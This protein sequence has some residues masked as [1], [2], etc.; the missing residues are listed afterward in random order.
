MLPLINGYQ[1]M[2]L[3]VVRK[4]K[5][6]FELFASFDHRI[7]EGLLVTNFLSELKRRILSYYYLNNGVANI[8]CHACGKSMSDEIELGYRGFIKVTLANG[9]DDNLCRN[10]F[11]GW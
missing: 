9:C 3:G 2:I 7:S 1:S 10:C 4:S 6:A 11:E 8:T 5:N